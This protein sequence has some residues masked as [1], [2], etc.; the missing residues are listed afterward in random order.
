MG[1]PIIAQGVI[2]IASSDVL[3]LL[4]TA[5][6]VIDVALCRTLQLTL[7]TQTHVLSNLRFMDLLN[8]W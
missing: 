1:D 3:L 2:V 5:S 6:Q 8:E 4:L 7:S